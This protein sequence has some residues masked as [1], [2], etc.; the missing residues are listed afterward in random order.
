MPRRREPPHSQTPVS[1]PQTKF[2]TQ[3]AFSLRPPF[4]SRLT[5]ARGPALGWGDASATAIVAAESPDRSRR[6]RPFDAF[7]GARRPS[8][9]ARAAVARELDLCGERVLGTRL[10]FRSGSLPLDRRARDCSTW[11]VCGTRE[12]FPC[13]RSPCA[14][15]PC[16]LCCRQSSSRSASPDIWRKAGRAVRRASSRSIASRLLITTRPRL[17]PVPDIRTAAFSARPWR[18]RQT[19]S[20][21]SSSCGR[22]PTKRV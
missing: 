9:R 17:P 8:L 15:S 22:S 14:S 20:G 16:C 4:P 13:R 19:S 5:S 10:R 6:S 21:R 1:R 18:H 11:R 12:L 3:P 7:F 2:A